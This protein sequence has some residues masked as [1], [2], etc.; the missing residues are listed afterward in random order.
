MSSPICKGALIRIISS[1]AVPAKYHQY[2][3]KTGTVEDVIDDK[4]IVRLHVTIGSMK[5]SIIKVSAG[6]FIV[7]K[8]SDPITATA[9][10]TTAVMASTNSLHLQTRPRS[11]SSPG[12]HVSS[13]SLLFQEG[14]RV[15][16]IGTE[17][18][19]QRFPLFVG[20]IGIIKEAPSK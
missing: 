15:I 6:A 10:A 4:Y 20:K 2:I 9:T 18:V 17:N 19:L 12:V 16:I 7:I 5:T 8:R 3:G 11:N 1:S 14:M 13:N